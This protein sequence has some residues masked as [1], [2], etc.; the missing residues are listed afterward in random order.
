MPLYP[1]IITLTGTIIAGIDLARNSDSYNSSE[2]E[3]GSGVVGA[4]CFMAIFTVIFGIV[5][6]AK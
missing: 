1:C 3:Y 4:F 5:H 6:F 2:K